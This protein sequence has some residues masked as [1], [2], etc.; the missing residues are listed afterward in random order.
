M[1]NVLRR[2]GFTHFTPVQAEA[3]D[4]ILNGRDVICQ[5]RTGTGKTLAFGLPA[6]MRI[7]NATLANGKRSSQGRMRAGRSPSMLVLCPTRELARQVSDELS[8][9]I[10]PF[11]LSSHV[12]H[13]GVSYDP[14]AAALR[15]GIDI[16]VGTP[17]RMIDHLN[18]G[19]LQLGECEIVALDEADEMLNMGF[20]ED[21]E[22]I[23][24][25]VGTDLSF[26]AQ[27]LLFSATTPPWVAKLARQYQ[28]NPLEVDTTGEEGG[29]RVAKTVRHVAMQLPPGSSKLSMLEEI[30]SYELSKQAQDDAP[31]EDDYTNDPIAAAAAQRKHTKRMNSRQAVYG[32][33]IVFTETKRQAD[34]IAMGGVFK[35][36]TA[37][38]IHGDVGQ[39]RRDAILNSFRAGKYN[40]LVATDVAARGIDIKDVDLVVQLDPPRDTDSYVHRSGRTGRAGNKG[41]S[42]L[43]FDANQV[44]DIL[45]IENELG[46][47]FQFDL[48]G[49][50][51]SDASLE[52]SSAATIAAYNEVPIGLAEIYADAAEDLL[53]DSNPVEVVSRF[54]ALISRNSGELKSRSMITGELGQLTVEVS[55]EGDAVVSLSEVI[56]C[57]GKLS[58]L[59][60]EAGSP[61]NDSIGSIQPNPG[62]NSAVFDMAEDD[63]RRLITFS[64]SAD[65][66]G[67]QF[68]TLKF[69]SI[70]RDRFMSNAYRGRGSRGGSNK[71]GGG[72]SRSGG[73]FGGF[74]GRYDNGMSS[75][76]NTRNDFSNRRGGYDGRGRGGGYDQNS[77]RGGGYDRNSG[78]GG[79]YNSFEW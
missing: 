68:S 38:V 34:Q 59:S 16:V 52:A 55:K 65:T 21:V 79:G 58:R 53:K 40:V 20:S 77:G 30:I 78:R 8:M 63:A 51:S 2:K 43:L 60:V 7:V 35:T 46:H 74:R 36:L 1:I 15:R 14:Q 4:P 18:R 3:C 39:G 11:S 29:A 67:L 23:L 61:F 12:F 25:H 41:V 19:N 32:K 9:M 27:C 70:D 69:L 42:V 24:S 57:V 6:I 50:P 47:G 22:T 66:G 17:G 71:G 72:N 26:K 45:R 64:K 10:S 5:S 13:G 62:T 49:P 76:R 28:H 31:D 44:S 54:I 75:G 37:E 73:N 56:N 48:V 33:T